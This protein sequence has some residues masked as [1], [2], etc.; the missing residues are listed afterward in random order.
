MVH[1]SH[2]VKRLKRRIIARGVDIKYPEFG[3]THADDFIIGDLN[4]VDV[5]ISSPK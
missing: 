4:E 3:E 1:G 2:M 5:V